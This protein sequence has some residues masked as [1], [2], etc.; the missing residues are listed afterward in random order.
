[1][2][3]TEVEQF[4][5]TGWYSEATLYL[6][7]YIYWCEAQKDPNSEETHFFVDKWKAE[8]KDN[9]FYHSVFEKDG[10]LEWLRIF[11][12]YDIDLD[13]LKKRFL[14]APIFEGKTFWQVKK[15]ILWLEE[16]TSITK[17]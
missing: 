4:I 17:D 13:I 8:N 10:T 9:L 2:K 11:E 14:E 15:D 6:Q 5:D 7:G 3:N 16:A 12:A 1:M